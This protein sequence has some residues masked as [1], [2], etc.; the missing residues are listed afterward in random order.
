MCMYI[1]ILYLYVFFR[2]VLYIYKAK[3]HLLIYMIHLYKVNRHFE[4]YIKC[5]LH[6]LNSSIGVDKNF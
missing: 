6:D 3:R 1:Y 5:V 4:V 2:N